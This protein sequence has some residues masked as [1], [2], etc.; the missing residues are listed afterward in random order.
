MSDD[1]AGSW[2]EGS[3]NADDGSN[4]KQTERHLESVPVSPEVAESDWFDETQSTPV[5]SPAPVDDVKGG[6]SATRSRA[7]F[8]GVVVATL[9]VLAGGAFLLSTV[10]GAGDDT[11][12]AAP[13]SLPP[14]PT[15][16][17]VSAATS[18]VECKASREESV[19]T[20]NGDGDTESVAG[21]ILA[22]Q[23][24]YYVE[25][26]ATDVEE[27]LSEES[28]ITDLEALQEG[29]DSVDKGT[30]HCL[31]ISAD[32]DDAA[33]VELTEIAPDGTQTVFKQRVTTTREEGDIQIVS[34]EDAS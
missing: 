22:F 21:V 17:P 13:L 10:A 14:T 33:A 6:A 18:D 9:L 24:A 11:A 30:E 20:G 25:R 26:D 5:S 12:E 32:G 29:I 15:T 27:L 8:A 34:I 28:T 7:L 3:S 4:D 16:E 23:H 2:F 19:T 31:E 1:D